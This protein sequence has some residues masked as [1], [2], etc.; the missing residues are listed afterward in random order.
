MNS[1]N[2]AKYHPR[3]SKISLGISALLVFGTS[4]ADTN[5]AGTTITTTLSGSSPIINN[6]TIS[7]TAPN[8]TY[9]I[10]TNAAST[11]ITNAGT[12]TTS[13]G[14][15]G[16]GI[17]STATSTNVTN[18]G[19]ITTSG[20]HGYALVV[21]STN[22]NIVNSGSISTSGQFGRG[23]LVF[24]SG[25][26]ISNSGTITL[27][28]STQSIGAI[29]IQSTS[30][31]LNN[32]GTISST[33]TDGVLLTAGSAVTQLSNTGS[34]S[35]S[36]AGKYGIKNA[37]SIATL[38]NSQ[39]GN[40]PLT[41]TGALP[42]NYKVILS[43]SSNYGKLSATS[44]TGAT[45]F[46]IDSGLVSSR[47]YL[48]VLSGFAAGNLAVTSGVYSGQSWTL[49]QQGTSGIWDLNFPGYI[50]TYIT[51]SNERGHS[52]LG[53]YLNSNETQF[54]TLTNELDLLSG[55]S[56][57]Q[58]IRR[59][60]PTTQTAGM[61]NVGGAQD[62]ASKILFERSGS[63]IADMHDFRSSYARYSS[64]YSG[65]S[66]F[67]LSSNSGFESIAQ[68]LAVKPVDSRLLPVSG[69]NH[70]THPYRPFSP[71]MTGGWIQG[72]YEI[73]DASTLSNSIGF[74]SKTFGIASA[75]EHALDDKNVAIL[76]IAPS[77]SVSDMKDGAGKISTN[78]FQYSASWLRVIDTLKVSSS[79]GY[80][81]SDYDSVRKIIVGS[82][83]ESASARYKGSLY[84]VN[85]SLSNLI[86]LQDSLHEPYLKLSYVMNKTDAYS[87]SGAGIYNITMD[88]TERSFLAT[89]IGT[90][91]QFNQPLFGSPST[92][93]VKP[94]ITYKSL[95]SDTVGKMQVS[96][97]SGIAEYDTRRIDRFT[98]GIGLED[99]SKVTS[100]SRLKFGLNVNLSSDVQSTQGYVQY[101]RSF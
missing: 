76:L 82:V 50:R 100:T 26:T 93:K 12:I 78:S 41:F 4:N 60:T 91:L 63:F 89:T 37:G 71:G 29:E 79:L 65:S 85:L 90:S 11:T 25:H 22:S 94:N 47:Q 83:N 13:S 38:S 28:G 51:S 70:S 55:S 9:A 40:T 49:T 84:S 2:L 10:S 15:G 77:R 32:S 56:F 68:F 87:E 44:V 61:S 7:I 97:G 88:K 99:I 27:T 74:K 31:T 98:Y 43:S 54:S 3:L 86:K 62:I 18:S 34:I 5:P 30:T 52:R 39:G 19:S 48:S 101:E 46:S 45:T 42:T 16:Y 33:Q 81:T 20:L 67:T 95:L 23:I 21:N 75:L 80:G 53:S 66:R 17:Y 72:F 1:S 36:L 8:D 57:D 6:G 69:D 73:G 58:A 96:G 92:I 14:S 24:Q 35:A 64:S 59:I